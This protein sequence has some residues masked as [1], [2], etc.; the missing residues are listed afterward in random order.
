MPYILYHNDQIH[1]VES[2]ENQFPLKFTGFLPSYKPPPWEEHHPAERTGWNF[3]LIETQGCFTLDFKPAN[4]L[5]VAVSARTVHRKISFH[6][7]HCF[8]SPW[9]SICGKQQGQLDNNN[10]GFSLQNS[11]PLP[12]QLKEATSQMRKV[13]LGSERKE[14]LVFIKVRGSHGNLVTARILSSL[15]QDTQPF[16]SYSIWLISAGILLLFLTL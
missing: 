9:D 6:W 5:C 7:P 16:F 15:F 8:L 11:S 13:N 14:S 4:I 1:F 3:V 2:P 10:S 12:V